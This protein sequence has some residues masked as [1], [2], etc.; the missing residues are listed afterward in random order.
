MGNRRTSNSPPG[1]SFDEFFRDQQQRLLQ[2]CWMSTLDRGAAADATQEAF[3]RAY[4]R[5]DTIVDGNPGA[6]IRSVALNLCRD[7]WRKEGHLTD[8]ALPELSAADSYAH[9]DLLSALEMLSGRQR[10]VVVLRYWAD[11]K[12]S[13]CAD[14]M[15]IST[16]SARQHLS[17]AHDRLRE[18][19][20]PDIEKELVS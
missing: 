10:E 11:L 4:V 18:V 7:R 8:R 3:T 12:L 15:E 6:W 5:W 16:S 13:D 2:L 9:T 17:R 19:V 1:Q 14:A 20:G